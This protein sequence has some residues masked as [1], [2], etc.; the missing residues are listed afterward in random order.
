MSISS[1][2]VRRVRVANSRPWSSNEI[3]IGS[4]IIDGPA[5]RLSSNPGASWGAIDARS[6]RAMAAAESLESETT[7]GVKAG[8]GTGVRARSVTGADAGAGEVV[9]CGVLV[10]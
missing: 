2:S 10:V 3:P 4:A 9:A 6:V 8:T 7:L 5:Q 1:L